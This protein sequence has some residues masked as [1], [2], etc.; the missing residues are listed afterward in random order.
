[1]TDWADHAACLSTAS[2]SDPTPQLSPRAAEKL[3]CLPCPV[4]T[5]CL[6]TALD[7]RVESGVWGG[8]SERERRALLRRRPAVASWAELLR[9]A[10]REYERG[11]GAVPGPGFDAAF[12][13]LFRE[14][15]VPLVGFLIKAGAR[16][17]DAEDAVQCAFIDL[18][19]VW[20]TVTHRAAWL[21]TTCYRAWL[22]LVRRNRADQLGHLLPEAV[23]RDATEDVPGRFLIL[24][25][26]WRLPPVQRTVMAFAFD[27][28]GPAETAA[29]M[30]VPA[31]NV[32]QNLRRARAAL[33]R[34][35]EENDEEDREGE[36]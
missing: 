7:N 21:R 22:R 4:R 6:A 31:A 13:A 36:E 11:A 25:L 26:L 24:E 33:A 5:E 35:L 27:G 20:E 34:F 3:V 32:R 1:M 2:D 8:M 9:S 28:C 12:E 14:R 10:R 15:F 18:A 16:R 30:G 17:P 19:G 23:A 29:A